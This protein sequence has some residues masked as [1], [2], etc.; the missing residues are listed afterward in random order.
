MDDKMNCHV[1]LAFSHLDM[2]AI[3]KIVEHF[4]HL[5]SADGVLEPVVM[6]TLQG[7]SE[8]ALDLVLDD[9][10]NMAAAN[11]GGFDGGFYRDEEPTYEEAIAMDEKDEITKL[12]PEFIKMMAKK[13][14]PPE[15]SNG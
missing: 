1:E 11:G 3:A 13:L 14:Y 4:Q 9:I 7:V 15:N 2:A 6:I 8:H 12:S 10:Q 5:I